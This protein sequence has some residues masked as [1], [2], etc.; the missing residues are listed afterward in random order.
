LEAWRD[1]KFFLLCLVVLRW[2]CDCET[3]GAMLPLPPALNRKGIDDATVAVRE[4]VVR[5]WK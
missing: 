4:L 3:T 1:L 2:W 5:G